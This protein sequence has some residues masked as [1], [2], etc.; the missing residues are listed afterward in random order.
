[1]IEIIL[2]TPEKIDEICSNLKF[3]SKPSL[4]IYAAYENDKDKELGCC[5]FELNGKIGRLY[6]TEIREVNLKFIE[7]GLLRST[8]ALMYDS[9]V[10]I[11]TCNGGVDLK[12]LKKLGFKEK[13]GEFSLSLNDSFLT[14]NC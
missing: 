13:D 2:A 5:G 10:E 6:F 11:V 3:E 9:G 12:I 8:L 7:D 1:M 4:K 14:R